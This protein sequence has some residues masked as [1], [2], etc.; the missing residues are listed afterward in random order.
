[1]DLI[2]LDMLDFDTSLVMGWLAPYHAVL[3]C[4]A[5][6]VTLAMHGIPSVV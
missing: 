6:I 2:L 1:M 5:K 3:D 4:Y